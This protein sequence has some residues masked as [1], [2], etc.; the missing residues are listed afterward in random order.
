VYFSSFYDKIYGGGYTSSYSYSYGTPLNAIS[1][2]A[3]R[4][5]VEGDAG[6]FGGDGNFGLLYSYP[7]D[8]SWDYF[9]YD[10]SDGLYDEHNVGSVRGKSVYGSTCDTTTP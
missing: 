5:I 3:S 2:L 7:F 8:Y 1:S 6:A 9:E 4:F 10:Y